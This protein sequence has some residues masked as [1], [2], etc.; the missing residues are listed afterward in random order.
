VVDINAVLDSIKPR[1]RD[2]PQ[3]TRIRDLFDRT[4]AAYQTDRTQGIKRELTSDWTKLK[5]RFDT[6]I[7]QVKKE[8]GLF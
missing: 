3:E 4:K 7:Q 5:A 8:T 2:F 6:A 1:M